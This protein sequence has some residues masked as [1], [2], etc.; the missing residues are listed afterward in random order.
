MPAEIN[1]LVEMGNNLD[2]LKLMM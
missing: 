2:S 1:K